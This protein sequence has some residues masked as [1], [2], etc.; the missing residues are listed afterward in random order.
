MNFEKFP[1]IATRGTAR[2]FI[3]VQVNFTKYVADCKHNYTISN[4]CTRN[5]WSGGNFGQEPDRPLW[6]FRQRPLVLHSFSC[7]S[8]VQYAIASSMQ[9]GILDTIRFSP[10]WSLYAGR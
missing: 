6:K 3:T 2:R 5:G 7:Q 9:Q 4:E 1:S 8:R 10:F